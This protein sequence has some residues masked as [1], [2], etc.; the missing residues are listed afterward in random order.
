MNGFQCNPQGATGTKP[1]ARPRVPFRFVAV[2]VFFF[3]LPTNTYPSRTV[4][5]RS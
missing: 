3:S 1:L 5:L 4:Q 2:K